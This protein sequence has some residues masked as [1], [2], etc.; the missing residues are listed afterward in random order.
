MEARM[1][2]AIRWY[3]E[4]EKR[5]RELEE[6][7]AKAKREVRAAKRLLHWYGLDCD[8]PRFVSKVEEEHRAY[9]NERR[10]IPERIQ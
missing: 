2:D 9:V 1:E 5:N 6:E 7:V 8:L 3:I 4:A 10:F